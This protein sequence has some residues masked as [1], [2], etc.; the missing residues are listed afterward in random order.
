[1]EKLLI[2]IC[3]TMPNT[4]VLVFTQSQYI[5][6]ASLTSSL[7]CHYTWEWYLNEIANSTHLELECYKFAETALPVTFNLQTGRV[8]GEN[9]Q[10]FYLFIF[11]VVAEVV[12]F[13]YHWRQL[14]ISYNLS[15][16]KHHNKCGMYYYFCVRST[17]VVISCFLLRCPG[18]KILQHRKFS[19]ARYS[20]FFGKKQFAAALGTAMTAPCIYYAMFSVAL[21]I[22]FLAL[23]EMVPSS[24]LCMQSAYLLE[25]SI[26]LTENTQ[27]H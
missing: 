16:A 24:E 2:A 18:T 10:H 21:C 8:Y 13:L 26:A 3:L 5:A 4:L 14:W 17:I 6:L 9:I 12:C 25:E 7:Q 11:W 1:M 20:F 15:N 22:I 27:S 23:Q 19:E